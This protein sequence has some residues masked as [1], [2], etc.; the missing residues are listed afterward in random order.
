LRSLTPTEAE[1]A[2]KWREKCW[3]NINRKKASPKP[4]LK[5]GALIKFTEPIAFGEYQKESIFT[6]VNP[7]RLLFQN[8]GTLFKLRRS[9]LQSNEWKLV[10]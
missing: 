2:V 8:N 9:T 4:K 10:V 6:V 3:E 5:K 1:F 7:R